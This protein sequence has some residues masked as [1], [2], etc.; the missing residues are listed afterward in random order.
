MTEPRLTVQHLRQ[1]KFCP[2][3]ARQWCER[4]GLD[5]RQLVREGLPISQ[6][7]AVGD[8]FAM[9]ASQ[10]VREEHGQQ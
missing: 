3:G 2:S 5:W 4:H 7:E 10:L 9:H 8:A 6:I 1:L